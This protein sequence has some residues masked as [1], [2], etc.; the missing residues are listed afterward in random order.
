MSE[1]RPPDSRQMEA[2]LLAFLVFLRI[3]LAPA[4]HEWAG[5]LQNAA[6]ALLLLYVLVKT[7]SKPTAGD[8][9]MVWGAF[10]YFGSAFFTIP[11]S[12]APRQSL[13]HFLYQSGDLFIFLVAAGLGARRVKWFTWAL[14]FACLVSAGFALRQHWGGFE[15]TL[16]VS[17]LSDYAR[18]TLKRGRVFGL[19][20]S[21]DMLAVTIAAALPVAFSLLLPGARRENSS[22][23]YWKRFRSGVLIA[24]FLVF[25]YVL[26]LTRSL[27][28]WLAAGAGICI[29]VFLLALAEP[30]SFFRRH[31]KKLAAV[32]A[33]VVVAG[34]AAIVISRGGHFLELDDRHN[35]LVMRLHNWAAAA[36]VSSEFPASGAGAGE[37]GLAMLKH[38]SAGGNEAQ[39]AHNSLLEALAETGV[40]GFIGLLL[41]FIG[42]FRRGLSKVRREVEGWS[43]ETRR[44]GSGLFAGAA[45]LLLHSFMDFSL[46]VPEA[47]V[48]FWL[49]AGLLASPESVE[50]KEK[51][52][53]LQGRLAVIIA[54]AALVL[55][56]GAS[57]YHMQAAKLMQK[58]RE[59]AR[60]GEWSS[61]LSASQKA[62][63]WRAADTE[64]LV[65]KARALAFAGEN[66]QN[67]KRAR[68]A[69]RR[70]IRLNPRQPFLHE[71]YGHLLAASE[72]ARA[73][74][75][76]R[77]AVALYPNSMGLNL[78]LGKWLMMQKEYEEAERVLKHAARC[79]S[80]IGEVLFQLS[81]LYFQQGEKD[82][83]GKFLKRAAFAP[84]VRA[85]RAEQY[86]LF[87][88]KQNRKDE[89]LDF[90]AKWMRRN[91][92][93]A[94]ELKKLQRSLADK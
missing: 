89:A 51:P 9:L 60:P 38:R 75:M 92:D 16:A 82:K 10:I 58:A 46:Q 39:H 13:H 93:H 37:Y 72:P 61:A 78:T 62:L 85:D 70:A 17:G 4:V 57:L 84:P 12:L 73:E 68:A 34:S 43:L 67:L 11:W 86:A 55:S 36:R 66:T 25:L 91:P 77:R 88:A 64:M 18:T 33:L 2:V 19:T 65:L 7:P 49:V 1:E 6:L 22:K 30:E 44:L 47:S 63:E 69:L 24:I 74:E 76:F 81:R 20:M 3:C 83:E 41:L 26:F 48:I 15:N 14:L 56:G 31:W 94:G 52:S 28:G 71:Y 32:A 80:A 27:G 90:L 54:F 40:P 23:E 35:P 29:F 79:G 53:S 42:F 5:F 21:P 8:R 50:I 59:K 87:L 45:A